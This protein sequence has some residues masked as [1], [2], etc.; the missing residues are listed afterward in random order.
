MEVYTGSFCKNQM[1]TQ[2]RGPGLWSGKPHLAVGCPSACSDRWGVGPSCSL[3]GQNRGFSGRRNARLTT[4]RKTKKRL[5]LHEL[6]N[7]LTRFS[8]DMCLWLKPKCTLVFKSQAAS[9]RAN[10]VTLINA[11]AGSV[12]QQVDSQLLLKKIW[13]VCKVSESEQLTTEH[14]LVECVWR[15]VVSTCLNKDHGHGSVESEG[16]LMNLLLA[17]TDCSYQWNSLERMINQQTKL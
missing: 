15:A 14:L 2:G 16:L 5:D 1:S 17:V 3:C 7:K 4:L 8:G 10:Q 11:W 6:M 9:L 12:R 13:I